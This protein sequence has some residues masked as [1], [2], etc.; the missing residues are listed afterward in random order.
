MD[1]IRLWQGKTIPFIQK[2]KGG[3]LICI[4]CT[5]A[6]PVPSSMTCVHGSNKIL[7]FRSKQMISLFGQ[8]QCEHRHPGFFVFEFVFAFS[9]LSLC[10]MSYKCRLWYLWAIHET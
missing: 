10:F 4:L 9:V 2:N 5:I 8:L 3:D 7:E 6:H 1:L